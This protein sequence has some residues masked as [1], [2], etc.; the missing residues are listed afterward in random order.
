MLVFRGVLNS[1]HLN[2][3][4][5]YRHAI[6]LGASSIIVTHTHPSG[7]AT[8][9]NEDINATQRLIDVGKLVGISLDD[10]IIIGYGSNQH[11]SIRGL[12]KLIFE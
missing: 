4:D 6:R 7:D 3:S 10:H 1:T 8:P 2:P 9:S 12:N 11:I 5:I